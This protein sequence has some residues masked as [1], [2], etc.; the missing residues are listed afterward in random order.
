MVKYLKYILCLPLC[1]LFVSCG[2]KN[3]RHDVRPL[4]KGAAIAVVLDASEKYIERTHRLFTRSGYSVKAV[5]TFKDEKGYDSKR[6]AEL[7][8][9][10]VY[11]SEIVKAANLHNVRNDLEVDYL[12][13]LGLKKTDPN[14]GRVIDLRTNEVIY[15]SNYTS[16][17]YE[18][19]ESIINYFISSMTG[20]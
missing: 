2:N 3:I 20:K 19:V 16:R 7:F 11:N 5:S 15:I 6:S 9:L 18:G 10:D 4:P 13:I 8:R 14:W 17:W 1:L 12:V